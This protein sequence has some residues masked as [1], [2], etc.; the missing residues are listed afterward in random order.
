V[1]DF[2]VTWH[3]HHAT[4]GHPIISLLNFVALVI[5]AWRLHELMRWEVH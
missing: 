4:K 3:E 2:H 5:P 1:T